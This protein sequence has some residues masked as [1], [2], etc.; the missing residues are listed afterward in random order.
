[1]AVKHGSGFVRDPRSDDILKNVNSG[2]LVYA[3]AISTDGLELFFTW[4][5]AITPT[6]Q[7]AIYRAARKRVGEPF[8]IP[9]RVAG[10]TGFVEGPTLSR[11]GRR[12]YYHKKVN[13]HFA[14]YLITRKRK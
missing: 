3:P 11:D 10:I 2:G 5:A 7:P 1:M 14:L 12:L 6:A 13:G 8:G 4:V 9:Q